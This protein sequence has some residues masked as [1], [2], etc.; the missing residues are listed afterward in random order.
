MYIRDIKHR[1]Y[2]QP[3]SNLPDEKRIIS[4]M[5]AYSFCLLQKD[6]VFQDAILKSNPVLVD[7]VSIVWAM[8]FLTG[9]KLKK[10]AGADLMAWEMERL[11]R[12]GGKCFFLGSKGSTLKKIFDRAKTD[13]PDVS[14]QYYEPPFKPAFTAEENESMVAAVN[15]FLPDVLF[16]GL[17]AP[18][19]EKWAAS[20]FEELKTNHI[21][22]IGAAFDFYARTVERAPKWM[23]RIGLEWFYRLVREPKRNWRRYILGNS[24]FIRL[25]LKEK[26][27]MISHNFRK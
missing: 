12:S 9:Q 16:I 13:Y 20:H 17:T 10:I 18:K 14:V 22:C 6:K 11:Q 7:G 1:F 15:S 21:C 26:I 5:N 25:I 8:R 23:I 4:T 27:K 24:E 19:Q 3:L 2:S